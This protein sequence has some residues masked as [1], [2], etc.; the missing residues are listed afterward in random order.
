MESN[1][2]IFGGTGYIGKHMVKASVKLGHPTYV[3]SRPNSTKSDLLEEFQSL[4]VNIVRGGLD[5]HE[6]IVS[7]LKE[8]DVV[9]S[10]LAYPQ[11]LDQLHIIEA[12]NVAGNIKRFLPSDFGCEEDRI[13]V[14]PPFQAFLDKKKRIRRA[15]E[16]AGIPYTY[17]SAN[18]F[19]AYFVNYLLRPR[20]KHDDIIVYGNGEA[21][22][23]LNFEEDIAM[24]TI[25]VATDPRT[26]NRVVVFRPPS[27]VVSQLELISIWE[28][29]TGQNFKRVH[30]S[31]EEILILAKTL[32]D[33]EN[34]PVSILHSVFVKGVTMNFELGDNDIEASR[35]YPDMQFA[36]V[37]QLLDVFLHD[38]PKSASAAFA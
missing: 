3:Y 34:I 31:E 20:E 21:K 16:A 11:V 25:K 6:K 15:I 18:C 32:P 22:V 17:V 13:S 37:E 19:G 5:E 4:G 28:K 23:V 35:L 14:L 38:P 12:I 2:L 33:P 1:I 27:N 36:T 24:Y 26:C 8:V 29:K 10:A 9:I 7:L 30:A